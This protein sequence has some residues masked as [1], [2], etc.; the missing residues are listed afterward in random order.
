MD[1]LAT[2]VATITPVP[3]PTPTVSDVV[4]E[5]ITMATTA[6]SRLVSSLPVIGTRLLLSAIAILVG[7]F[8]IR[9]GRRLVDRLIHN[10]QASKYQT[11]QQRETFASLVNSVMSYLMY[12]VIATVVLSIFGVNISSILAVAGVGG[13][14]IG[15]GAQTLVKDVISGVFLWA[16]GNLTVGDT[17]QVNG[18]TGT[19]ESVSLR[20]TTLRDYNGSL[21]VVPN[22]DI[23]TVTNMSRGR[24]RAI[25]E[26]RLNYEEDLDTMLRVLR[27]EMDNTKDVNGLC[28]IPQVQGITGMVGDSITVQIAALCEAASAVDVERELRRRIKLRFDREEILF[29]HAPVMPTPRTEK[30]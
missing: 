28:E 20:T 9:L 3:T 10:K 15:F 18:M 1:D 11:P 12:F 2:A 17:V 27:D 8:I 24:R 23:R 22:G 13:V 29:P 14:A 19:V 30:A 7:Y 21:Y 26:V 4:N 16:E 5:G 6:T 25:V